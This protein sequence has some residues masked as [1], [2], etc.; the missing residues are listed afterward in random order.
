[1]K[2]EKKAKTQPLGTR[3]GKGTAKLIKKKIQNTESRQEQAL[4]GKMNPCGEVH[5]IILCP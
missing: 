3:G 5:Q 4:G 2:N 1:M